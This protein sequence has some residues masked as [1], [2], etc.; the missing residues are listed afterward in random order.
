MS[1]PFDS[2]VRDLPDGA[3]KYFWGTP[4]VTLSLK[5]LNWL[6]GLHVSPEKLASADDEV[7]FGD[8]R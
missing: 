5:E 8:F 7:K 1:R 3:V 2:K 6:E 4:A